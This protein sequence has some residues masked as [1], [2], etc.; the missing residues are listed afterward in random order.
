MTMN[1]L[2]TR[3][4]LIS[5]NNSSTLN[6]N[7]SLFMKQRSSLAASSTKLTP[8]SHPMQN[9]I[10]HTILTLQNSV[11]C[12]LH[13]NFITSVSAFFRQE[14]SMQKKNRQEVTACIFSNTPNGSQPSTIPKLMR[15]GYI[16]VNGL[17]WDY[18]HY[19]TTNS[20]I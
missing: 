12:I 20:H 6:V 18:Q 9:F 4:L 11:I 16:E 19:N 3:K 2:N 5:S 14:F 1:H 15:C 13:I 7:P 10:I 8:S 17:V